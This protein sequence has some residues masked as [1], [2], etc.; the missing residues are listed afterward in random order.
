MLVGGGQIDSFL[1]GQGRLYFL[2][3]VQDLLHVHHYLRHAAL[4]EI[5][6]LDKVGLDL[7]RLEHLRKEKTVVVG[8]E[9]V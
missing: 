3:L 4:V 7:R 9:L 6:S 8:E 2:L 5:F 1:E